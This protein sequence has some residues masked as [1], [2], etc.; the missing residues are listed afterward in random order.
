MEDSTATQQKL[1][2]VSELIETLSRKQGAH[3]EA[4]VS[5]L[6]ALEAELRRA[7][8]SLTEGADPGIVFSQLSSGIL[9]KKPLSN[10]ETHNKRLYKYIS[11]LGKNID[12]LK[13]LPDAPL[14]FHE[15]DLDHKSL[16]EAIAEYALHFSVGH[17]VAEGA[18]FSAALAE[19]GAVEAEKDRETF[20]KLREIKE[21]ERRLAGGDLGPLMA[22][23]EANEPALREA[24]SELPPLAR[25]QFLLGRLEAGDSP[26]VVL[27]EARRL[28]AGRS[29]AETSR[30]L[31]FLFWLRGR[32]ESPKSFA[33]G[34]AP[35]AAR[36]R[37]AAF[38]GN[39]QLTALR[40]VFRRTACEFCA[41]PAQ[42]SLFSVFR[43]SVAAFPQFAGAVE[44]PG[45][46]AGLSL[47][48]GREFAFHSLIVCPVSREV[49]TRENPPVLL[50]CGHVVSD[51][52]A[53]RLSQMR[54]ANGPP[55][56]ALK[57]PICHK[58]QRYNETRVLNID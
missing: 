2:K 56:R 57:C 53:K 32:D 20:E 44:S 1:S 4:V 23:I 12:K 13:T 28:F 48:L 24:E 40:A 30:F 25:R 34:S 22:W 35:P 33:A 16:R 6:D 14:M 17:E 10:I 11:K 38:C 42:N 58:D 9:Q 18:D 3:R 45:Q 54:A 21:I 8:A 51:A 37:Y 55:L 41:V 15:D 26:R 36:A 27:E 39:E 7:E 47:D 49:C 5:N 29:D 19:L 46:P 31:A 43:A 52:S 50:V